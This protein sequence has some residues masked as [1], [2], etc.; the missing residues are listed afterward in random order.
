MNYAL[1][2]AWTLAAAPHVT[3]KQGRHFA[4]HQ[5]PH[6]AASAIATV[7][8]EANLFPLDE[9]G[10]LCASLLLVMGALESGWQLHISGDGGRALGPFGEWTGGEAR[11]Q[12][13]I[14][15][16]RHYAGTVRWA[17][18]ACPEQLIAPLAGDRCG[19]SRTHTIRWAQIAR[20]YREVEV[21]P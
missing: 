4:S 20:L 13:W 16:T 9:T 11:A 1:L 19:G 2:L 6:E 5:L 8:T 12:S 18:S 10:K 17:M 3:D 15:S 21:S 14:S 7:C